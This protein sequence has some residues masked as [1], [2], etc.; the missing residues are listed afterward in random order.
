MTECRARASPIWS[1]CVVFS[2]DADTWHGHP[3]ELLTPDGVK[4]HS[5]APYYDTVSK[6]VYIKVPNVSTMCGARPSDDATIKNEAREFN[7][8]QYMR[9][10]LSAVLLRGFYRASRGVAKVARDLPGR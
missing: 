9:D 1:R 3:D 4:R 7:P 8:E 2:T 10:W 5:V 6:H